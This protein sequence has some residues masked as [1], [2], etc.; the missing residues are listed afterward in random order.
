MIGDKK[1]WD[2]DV[3]LPNR[4]KPELGYVC[5]SDWRF[6]EDLIWLKY[7]H[8]KIAH[9]WKIRLEEQQRHDRRLRN[10]RNEERGIKK[11]TKYIKFN[12]WIIIASNVL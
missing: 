4:Y 10:K 2:I 1:Y 5:P 6:R 7:D 3:D 12:I 8:M 11:W 9:K